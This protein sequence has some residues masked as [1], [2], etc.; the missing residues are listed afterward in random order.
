MNT[1]SSPMNYHGNYK[2]SRFF[3]GWYF[4]LT[5][6][7][8]S[9]CIA[10]IPGI[11]FS[12]NA[13]EN[14]SFIQTLD[15]NN[16]NFKYFQ[17][18]V[19]SFNASN[20]PFKVTIDKSSFSLNGISLDICTNSSKVK[21]AISFANIRYWKDSLINPGSMGFYNYIPF[22]ECYSHVA[23]LDGNL[24]GTLLFNKEK[25][26]FNGGKIYIE[27]NWGKSFP[28]QW[29]WVQCNSFNTRN[30]A[31]TCSLAKIPFL[32]GSFQGFLIGLFIDNNF[33]KFTTINRSTIALS[34]GNTLSIVT[35][36]KNLK[37]TIDASSLYDDFILCYGPKNGS[38]SPYVNE[39][40]TGNIY[41]KLENIKNSSILYEGF[42]VNAG[43][44][45]GGNFINKLKH[46][47]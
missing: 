26:N 6:K 19:S 32:K 39:S 30:V 10:L 31:L 21:G 37:L 38:M 42:G 43:I 22:M 8:N 23:A 7:D 13:E 35:T 28:S 3:E 24:T 17:Y 45:Y 44:E 20:K 29:I 2:K 36:N 1:F 12:E 15:G 4:K 14:H 11:S 46:H 16:K 18:K 5:T 27:K 41:I 34:F 33:Y 40:I 9:R 47:S 25:I